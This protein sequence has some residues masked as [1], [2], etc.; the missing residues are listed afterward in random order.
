MVPDLF[1][2]D[3]IRSPQAERP[4]G[5]ITRS[6][7]PN[8]RFQ[9]YL[10]E[11]RG[12][13]QPVPPQAVGQSPDAPP[14]KDKATSRAETTDSEEGADQSDPTNVA[15]EAPV[16]PSPGPVPRERPE[17]AGPVQGV[18][19]ER[20]VVPTAPAV[21][22]PIVARP[23]DQPVFHR[24][25][26]PPPSTSPPVE[27]PPA[28]DQPDK[29]EATARVVE[30]DGS[31]TD[32]SNF[33][34]NPIRPRPRVQVDAAALSIET[35]DQ[36]EPP[37]DSDQSALP[38]KSPVGRRDPAPVKQVAPDGGF[39]PVQKT[40]AAQAEPAALPDRLPVAASQSAQKAELRLESSEED[41]AEAA[42]DGRARADGPRVPV[43]PAPGQVV[44]ARA[45][46]RGGSGDGAASTLGRFLVKGA[47]ESGAG[48][49][50]SDASGEPT[51]RLQSD[52]TREASSSPSIRTATG[53]ST[54]ATVGQLLTSAVSTSDDVES[55]ARVLSASN[56]SGRHQVTL[57]L[58]P[59]ELGQIR[60]DVRMHRQVMTLRVDAEN[61]GVA[62]LIESRLPELRDALAGHGIRVDRSEV[63][64]RST[65]S[66]DS[67]T[68]QQDHSHRS[69]PD[70]GNGG[71]GESDRSWSGAER[72]GGTRSDENP[73]Q[74]PSGG[75]Q[76]EFGEGR[77]SWQSDWTDAN[78][79]FDEEFQGLNLV[80]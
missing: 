49:R 71:F 36:T 78:A 13:R 64:V 2:A 80:A 56:R 70:S 65:S 45:N 68:T 73:G 40:P 62:Q 12:S 44:V 5:P 32:A 79:A 66:A 48:S 8:E 33:E 43:K 24:S 29:A 11:A 60:V 28:S 4:D 34:G 76:Q 46:V 57:Q 22:G 26:A 55:A 47:D 39:P 3:L 74:G 41:S 18:P 52:G 51:F 30:L 17:A 19:I 61:R 16:A 14:V 7:A 31:R 20:P 77:G 21:L 25:N 53:S 42:S 59:P 10:H 15:P 35:T 58:D 23:I 6:E 27:L 9:D 50:P 38:M 75:Q 37:A 63:F 54:A 72:F 69:S 67:G 1:A